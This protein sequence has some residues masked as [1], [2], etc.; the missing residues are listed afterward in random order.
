MGHPGGIPRKV[1]YS[2]DNDWDG[3]DNRRRCEEKEVKVLREHLPRQVVG[4]EQPVDQLQA[5][6]QGRLQL[7]ALQQGPQVQGVR[8][9]GSRFIGMHCKGEEKE[10]TIGGRYRGRSGG[11]RDS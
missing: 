9:E 4:V 1:L 2:K 7:A 5:L 8:V 6:Q 3:L 10:L 11:G